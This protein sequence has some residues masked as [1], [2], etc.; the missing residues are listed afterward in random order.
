MN[1][2]R[3]YMD[4]IQAPAGLKARVL[5]GE[6][7][8][9]ARPALAVGALAACCLVAAVGGWQM[10]QGRALAEP[11]PTAGVAAT[12][13]MSQ[14]A[15]QEGDYTLV[16]EDAFGGQPHN[17]PDKPVYDYPDCTG[18]DAIAGDYA[19]PEGWFEERLSAQEIITVLGGTDKVPWTL[20]WTGFGLDGT[21]IYDRDGQPWRITIQGQRGE[22]TL[23]L[24]LWPGREPLIDLIYADAG[25]ETVNG[26]EVT[27]YSLYHDKD[28]DGTKEYTYHADYFDGTMGVNFTCTSEEQG[29]AAWLTSLV[30]GSSFTAEGLTAPVDGTHTDLGT[31][32][33]Y[34]SGELTLAQAYEQELAPYSI[35]GL[36]PEE[37]AD[38]V[39]SCQAMRESRVHPILGIRTTG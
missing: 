20:D 27:T 38:L 14:Q 33:P 35:K 11:D 31:G 6:R 37:A 26:M 13:Q 17:F 4:R 18:S 8:R 7:P 2:Y 19:Y 30:V 25:T 1:R 24:E 23:C 5:A 21:V 16:V 32:R 36:E 15:A 28:G 3:N 29:T 39:N 12:P 22:D 34:G 10:W 9:R